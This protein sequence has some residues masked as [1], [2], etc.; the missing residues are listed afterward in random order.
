MQTQ[1]A[2]SANTRVIHIT[3]LEFH[4]LVGICSSGNL[5]P[6]INKQNERDEAVVF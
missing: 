1:K 2:T 3:L 6:N 5:I 4:T